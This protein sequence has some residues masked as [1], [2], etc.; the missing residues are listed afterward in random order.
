MRIAM[1][2]RTRTTVDG[3][4]WLS[5]YNRA[6]AEFGTRALWNMRQLSEPTPYDALAAARQLRI[7]GDLDARRLAELLEQSA[8]A[9]L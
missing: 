1:A 6:F 7:E 2:Q 9:D 3:Y 5:L 8:R 4:N